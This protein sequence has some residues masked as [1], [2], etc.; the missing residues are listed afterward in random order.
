M[1]QR[2]RQLCN[3]KRHTSH[4]TSEDIRVIKSR[5]M[6]WLEHVLR[7]GD[8]VIEFRISVRKYSDTF[9]RVILGQFTGRD[10]VNRVYPMK[11]TK[12]M[13]LL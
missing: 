1:K 11:N 13:R 6:R 5:R 9:W 2:C 10:D 4:Y 7:K 3:D 8:F 12:H